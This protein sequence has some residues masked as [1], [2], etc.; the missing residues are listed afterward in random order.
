MDRLKALAFCKKHRHREFY[1]PIVLEPGII[2]RRGK[3][4]QATKSLAHMLF[5]NIRGMTLLDIGCNCGFF[6]FEGLHRGAIEAMGIDND[7]NALEIANEISDVLGYRVTFR[8]GDIEKIQM[9]KKFDVVLIMNILHELNDC[10]AVIT[11]CLQH[12]NKLLV[13]EH[14]EEQER[15]FPRSPC[16][17]IQSPRCAGQ[18]KVSL[19]EV[20]PGSRIFDLDA[21]RDHDE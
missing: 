12:T 1:Q 2:E 19:F 21:I 14:E 18:R 6:L 20:A 3:W 15:Y 13:I 16:F 10:A 8:Y 17:Q 7:A 5:A 11:K 4:N 9:E